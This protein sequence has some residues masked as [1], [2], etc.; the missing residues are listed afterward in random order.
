MSSPVTSSLFFIYT[1]GDAVLFTIAL[2]DCFALLCISV[3]NLVILSDLEC[4]YI[5]AASCC[6]KLNYLVPI[7]LVLHGILTLGM[8]YNWHVFLLLL[9]LGPFL[10]LFNK[11]LR[12]PPGS[13]GQYDPTQIHNRSYI[14]VFIREAMVKLGFFIVFFF[15]Y[16]YSLIYSLIA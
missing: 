9:Q 8:F 12:V 5:N 10:Y 13:S 11:F 2:S 15:I 1:A 3:H 4:D 14:K 6:E 16:L 7:E